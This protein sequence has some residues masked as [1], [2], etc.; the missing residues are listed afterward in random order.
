MQA[1]LC[2]KY[3][4]PPLNPATSTQV[5]HKAMWFIRETA[6]TRKALDAALT[7]VN[8]LSSCSPNTSLESVSTAGRAGP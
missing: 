1:R 8:G 3:M 7:I 2:E 4:R 5:T 6:D